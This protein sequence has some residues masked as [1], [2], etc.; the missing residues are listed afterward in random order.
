MPIKNRPW[1]GCSIGK[2]LHYKAIHLAAC[3]F[4]NQESHISLL[5]IN[6][7]TRPHVQNRSERFVKCSDAVDSIMHRGRYSAIAFQL[8][9]PPR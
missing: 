3:Q 6:I 8:N 1:H 7:S 9:T 2:A 5:A 4:E